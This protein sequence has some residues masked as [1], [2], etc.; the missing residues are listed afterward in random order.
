MA[1]HAVIPAA[2]LSRR[3][4]QPKLVMDLAGQ[5]VIARLLSVLQC[6]SVASTTIVHRRADHELHAEIQ[7]VISSFPADYKKISVVTPKVDPPD[8]RASVEHALSLIQTNFEPAESDA[9]LLIPADHPILEAET[10]AELASLWE[11]ERPEILIPTYQGIGGHPTFFRWS[12]A[13]EVKNIPSDKGINWLLRDKQRALKHPVKSES[14]ICDLDTPEDFDR[15][16]AKLGA[17]D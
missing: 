9:W 7:R 2:G 6:D 10:L 3:M 4:G 13:I 14:V 8:M 1:I 12:V 17:I 11:T 5:S 16:V 15:L